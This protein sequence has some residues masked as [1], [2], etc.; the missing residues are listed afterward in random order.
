MI[1]SMIAAMA[2]NRVIGKDNDLPWHLPDDFKYFQEKTKNH[3]VIMGR[4]NWESLPHRFKPLPRR[5]NIII[6][7]QQDYKAQGGH[8]YHTLDEALDFSKASGEKEVF[9]IGG[10]EI[11]R[12]ALAGAH[13]IFLTEIEG[14]FEGA[15]TFPEFST[16]DWSETSRIHHTADDRHSHAFDFVTYERK[17][18]G[19]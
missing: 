4:K 18:S 16:R 13:R 11:Y 7:K 12:M 6:T 19:Y 15:V 17:N 14:T 3:H 8:V 2:Q 1:I 9:I 5:T 10:G